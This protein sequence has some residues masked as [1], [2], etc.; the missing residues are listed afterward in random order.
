MTRVQELAEKARGLNADEM[1]HLVDEIVS[2]EPLSQEDLDAIWAREAHERHLAY[3]AGKVQM[4][5]FE[6]V[7]GRLRSR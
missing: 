5:P 3:R 2:P 7:L 6:E 1:L 4:I